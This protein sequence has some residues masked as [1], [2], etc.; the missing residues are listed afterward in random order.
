MINSNANT[1]VQA[2]P[3]KT[4]TSVFTSGVTGFEVKGPL[5]VHMQE[6]GNV[7]CNYNGGSGNI[8]FAALSGFDFVV[9]YDF[10]SID[11]DVSCIISKA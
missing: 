4:T 11:V 6:N 9:D 3:I 10:D 5:L 2:F 1:P 8:T 7:T